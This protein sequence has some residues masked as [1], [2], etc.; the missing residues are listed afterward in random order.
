LIE[1][2]FW[3]VIACWPGVLWRWGGL[4]IDLIANGFV[5]RLQSCLDWSGKLTVFEQVFGEI[6]KTK[7][8]TGNSGNREKDGKLKNRKFHP[9]VQAKPTKKVKT[10]SPNIQNQPTFPLLCISFTLFFFL[11]VH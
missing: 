5:E 3:I 8:L 9:I 10:S 1:L 4:W 11:R 6:V 7:K 2:T